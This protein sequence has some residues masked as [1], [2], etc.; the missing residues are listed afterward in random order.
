VRVV[1][2]AS[3]HVAQATLSNLPDARSSA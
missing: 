1:R 2:K 3:A